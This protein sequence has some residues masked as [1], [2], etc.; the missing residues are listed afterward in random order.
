MQSYFVL[1]SCVAIKRKA[2]GTFVASFADV[3]MYDTFSSSASDYTYMRHRMNKM[4]E[5]THFRF[6]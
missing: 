4:E 5:C 3:S 2:S 6:F 1:I